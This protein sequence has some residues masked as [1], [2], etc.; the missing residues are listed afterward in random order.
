MRHIFDFINIRNICAMALSGC[1]AA[2]VH[3][4]NEFGY[5]Y[6]PDVSSTEAVAAGSPD[7]TFDVSATG[8]A[9]YTI[10]VKVPAGTGGLQPSLSIVYNSQA[11]NGIAGWGCNISGLSSITHAPKDIYHDGAAM[12]L[13]RSAD[14]AYYLDGQRLILVSGTVGAEGTVYCPE[15]DPFT[16]IIVHRTSLATVTGLW[17]EVQASNGMKYYYGQNIAAR[18]IYYYGYMSFI[19]SWHLDRMEDPFGNCMTYTYSKLDGIMYPATVTYGNNVNVSAGTTHTVSFA[20]ETRADVMHFML[21]GSVKGSMNQRLKTITCK[22]GNSVYRTYEL[23]YNTTGDD[24]T[25]KYSRLTNI[26]EKNGAG[27]ALKPLSLSW[28]YLPAFSQGV[29][30]PTLPSTYIW[31]GGAYR[32]I[33]Y[34]DQNY[35]AADIDGDGLDD[36]IGTFSYSGKSYIYINRASLNSSGNAQYDGNWY[37]DLGFSTGDRFPCVLD[38]DGDGVNDLLSPNASIFTGQYPQKVQFKFIG[39]SLNNQSVYFNLYHSSEMPE[40]ATG[41]I[42]NDGRGDI[43]CIEKGHTSNK[44]TCE[45][46]G[47]GIMTSLNYFDFSLPSRPERMFVSDYDSDGLEDILV[48]Y[49]GGYTVFWNQGG[50]LSSSTFSDNNK[51]VG[52]N[53][54]NVRKIWP[55]DFNGDGQMDFLMNGTMDSNWYFA[56][57][58]GNG[59]FTKQLACNLGLY[60]QDFTD[61]DDDVFD[62]HIYDFDFDGKS[63]AVITKAMYT[64]KQD[65][66]LWIVLNTWG[67]FNTTYTNWMRST[68]SGL[69]QVASA[70]SKRSSDALQTKFVHGDFNGDGQVELMNYG[71]NCYSSTNANSNP[72]WR[73]YGNSNFSARRGKVTCITDGYGGTTN[74]SYASFAQDNFYTKRSGNSYPIANYTLPLHAVKAVTI[75]NGAAGSMTTDYRYC[76]LKVHLQ[77]RGLLGLTSRTV[78]NTTLGTVM[79]SGVKSWNT[80]FYIPS[81]TYTKTTVDGK[82]AE[83]NVTMTVVDKG[84]KKYFAFPATQTDKDLDGNT[85]TTTRQFNT[86]YGYPTEEKADFGNSMYK[87]VQYGN[88]VLAGNSYKPRLITT[89][90]KHTDHASVFTQKTFIA[91]NAAKGCRAQMVENYNTSLPLTTDYTYDAFGNVA[92]TKVSGQGVSQ[93]TTYYE[94]DATGRFVKRIYTSPSSSVSSFTYDVWGNVLTEKD[95]T[96]S[97]NIYTTT[98]LY[99]QWG[100]RTTTYYPAGRQT[101]FRSGWGSVASKRYFTLTQGT[102]QPWVKTWYDNKGREVLTETVGPCNMQIRQTT[103]YNNKGQVIL[104]QFVSGSLTTTETWTYDGRGRVASFSGAAGQNISY[105]YGNRSVMSLSNGISRTKTTDAWGNIKSSVDPVATVSYSYHSLGKPKSVTAG[106]ATFSMTYFDTGMQQTLTDPNAGISAYTY[107]AAGRLRQSIDGRGKTT[108]NTYDAQGRIVTTTIDGIVTSY[109]YGTWGYE[110]HRLTRQ[111]TGNNS[112]SFTYDRRGRVAT[113]TRQIEEISFVFRYSNIIC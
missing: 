21:D 76:G 67:E 52:T 34:S 95:E 24:T 14:R 25:T 48:F 66:F 40:Y 96:E 11:G 56:L 101:T 4:Q 45:I 43:I 12:A 3:G 72:V 57:N 55:G 41:D 110:T 19:H 91:Y 62:C 83:T 82:T 44:Y 61:R 7:G 109:T 49:N 74:I 84:S 59:I 28:L 94:Y 33:S 100:N 50:G 102:G 8:A 35:M 47:N 108:V 89:T 20:Y 77:G 85:V 15:S 71:Y 107:D 78:T 60:D 105:T 1:F 68:G 54:G 37:Y 10:P 32:T 53:I 9:V 98:H 36:L 87:T 92:T 81:G 70:T 97:N 46:I 65:R 42:D 39:G 17:F 51:M 58:N 16:K 113:E 88:Y 63:D 112:I 13:S 103:S 73:R 31:S 5:P 79:E 93:L 26:T 30:T 80:T 29:Q 75:N 99:D 18:L 6:A 111:Q 22:T 38:F 106:G 64:K 90:Q 69:V 104:K 86:T 2:T 27:E 23:Q